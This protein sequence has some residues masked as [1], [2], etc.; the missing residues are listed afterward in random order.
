[1][2]IVTGAA[3]GLGRAYARELCQ[4]GAA[5]VAS[6]IDGDA[7][8]GLAGAI[9]GVPGSVHTLA[10]D[11][12]DP[13]APAALLDAALR[14][15]GQLHGLVSNAGLLRSGPILLPGV[16]ASAKPP[17]GLLTP[18][19]GLSDQPGL[20]RPEQERHRAS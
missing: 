13:H 19:S 8:S 16:L 11:I 6:D 3:R 17:P 18:D 9:G 20:A 7:L 4:Q 5:V 10:C 2:V 1:V 12:T 14:R 15:Y